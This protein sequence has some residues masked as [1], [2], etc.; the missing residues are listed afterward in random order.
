MDAL[1]LAFASVG[2]L[3]LGIALP[4]QGRDATTTW[5]STPAVEVEIE[6]EEYA[7][8]GERPTLV[9]E[10]DL[11]VLVLRGEP[12]QPYLVAFG[13][14]RMEWKPFPGVLLDIDVLAVLCSGLLD[15]FGCAYVPVDDQLEIPDQFELMFQAMLWEHDGDPFPVLVSNPVFVP[16]RPYD[17][18]PPD[19]MPAEALWVRIETPEMPTAAELVCLCGQPPQ[20]A[21][22]FT[23]TVPTSGHVLRVDGVRHAGRFTRVLT[24][25][26]RP[27]DAELVMERLEQFE[28]LVPLGYWVGKVEILVRDHQRD[29]PVFVETKP[30]PISK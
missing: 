27:S 21:A 10:R 17:T 14:Q 25:L 13:M 6:G 26:E 8:V 24:T 22:L 29:P 20:V 4:A 19:P 7:V 1:H 28:V 11:R 9:Y 23:I 3:A 16:L 12:A 15:V 2:A 30:R 5:V 18:D